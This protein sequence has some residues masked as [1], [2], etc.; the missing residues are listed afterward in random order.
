[1]A[2]VEPA[3]APNTTAEIESTTIVAERFAPDF[4]H[5]AKRLA[6]SANRRS[7]ATARAV[8]ARLVQFRRSTEVLE[9]EIRQAASARSTLLPPVVP[10]TSPAGALEQPSDPDDFYGPSAALIAGGDQ[11]RTSAAVAREVRS[12]EARL[13]AFPVIAPGAKRQLTLLRGDVARQRRLWRV[14][15]AFG[16]AV[17]VAIGGLVYA[18]SGSGDTKSPSLHVKVA[19]Q[20]TQSQPVATTTAPVTQAPLTPQSPLSSVAGSAPVAP[21][22]TRPAGAPTRP[23]T[24]NSAAPAPL[25]EQPPATSSPPPPAPSTAPNP[26]CQISPNLCP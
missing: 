12:S 3:E 2:A 18:A 4:D 17:A 21:G 10:P 14:A 26:F 24:S 23:A 19:Q 7:T 22:T 5:T 9:Q 16:A 1:M 6:R 13:T 25:P 20:P 8:R 11:V 15:V